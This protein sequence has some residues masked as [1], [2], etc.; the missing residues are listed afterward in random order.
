M[1]V[2]TKGIVISTLR[3]QD[4]NMIVKCYTASDG[5]KSYF[6]R[7]AFGSKRVGHKM[8]YFQP[9]TVLEMEATHKNKGTLEYIQEIKLAFP[10]ETIHLNVVKSTMALFL[11]EM[12]NVTIQEEECNQDLFN[13]L[14]TA[15]LWL[16]THHHIANFH[17]IFLM[18]MTK[19]HGFYPDTT[20]D[21]FPY[22]DLLDGM[23]TNEIRST[24][25][26]ENET[27]LMKR[28]LALKFDQAQN[29]FNVTERQTLLKVLLE[30]YQLH[31]GNFRTPKSLDVL[32]EV[33]A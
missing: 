11:S 23:F 14:E 24:C 4:K 17:L 29:E 16:D 10:L 6:V 25:L 33:F 13:F 5:V 22:F 26:N 21:V 8:A 27:R 12:L 30:Y 2:K 32:K 18:E 1:L 20:A 19:F 28:L 3:Y 9:L 31:L 7:G 15:I